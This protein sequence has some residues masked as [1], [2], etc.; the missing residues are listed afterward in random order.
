MVIKRKMNIFN[1]HF[2]LILES[3]WLYADI[4]KWLIFRFFVLH[5]FSR[6][7]TNKKNKVG[8]K[9]TFFINDWKYMKQKALHKFTFVSG[10]TKGFFWKSKQQ[11]Y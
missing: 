6:K 4:W 10:G 8:I 9:T 3:E 1:L 5:F 2:C 11:T 7:S